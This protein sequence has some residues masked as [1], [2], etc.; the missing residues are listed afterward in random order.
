MINESQVKQIILDLQANKETPR[1][2]V[3]LCVGFMMYVRDKHLNNN[4]HVDA[5]KATEVIKYLKSKV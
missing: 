5:N 4:N 2:S 1:S 3:M